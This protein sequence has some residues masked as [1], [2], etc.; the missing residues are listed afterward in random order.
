MPVASPVEDLPARRGVRRLGVPRTMATAGA[1]VLLVVACGSAPGTVIEGPA[2]G[3]VIE[4]PAVTVTLTEQ[5]I[6]QGF[7]D[8]GLKIVATAGDAISETEM[9]VWEAATPEQRSRGLMGVRDLAGRDGMI[10]VYSEDRSTS[11]TMRNTLIDLSIAFFDAAGDFMDAF[12]MSP[13]TAEPC[14][15]YRTPE[16]FRLAL[17][18]PA[19]QLGR[20]GIGPGA[21]ATLGSRC[22]TP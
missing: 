4:G 16:G 18:V 19:G 22:N 1:C 5:E 3:T 8:V 2:P 7:G 12:E 20:W 13:C 14:P 17:E 6:P 11:F 15:T 21:T 9:C 10:F